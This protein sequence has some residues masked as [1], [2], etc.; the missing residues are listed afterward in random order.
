MVFEV[1]DLWPD[2]PIAM[3]ILKNPFLIYLAKSLEL[4]AYKHSNSIV[5]L[6]P[7]MKKGIVSKKIDAKKIAVIPNSSD[8][9]KFEL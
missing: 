3:K 1:R 9:D 4:W 8:L 7:Q 6:S 5:A 2:V